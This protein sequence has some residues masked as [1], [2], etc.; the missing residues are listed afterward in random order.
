MF[1]AAQSHTPATETHPMEV[2][3]AQLHAW[4]DDSLD[5]PWDRA[6]I[7]T[8]P[9]HVRKRFDTRCPTEQ[10]VQMTLAV[11]VR[12]GVL[13]SPR[14][15]GSDHRYAFAA[16][17]RYPEQFGVVGPVDPATPEVEEMVRT[18][19]QRPGGLA[20][21]VAVLPGAPEPLD[22]RGY[23]RIFAAAGSGLTYRCV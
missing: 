22:G 23:G 5:H 17:E 2:V 8:L 7:A 19:R 14:L 13:T 3:D 20:V 16:A 4:D 6:W 1:P 12:A 18:Y 15:Y 9:E 21:R 10:L 11:G